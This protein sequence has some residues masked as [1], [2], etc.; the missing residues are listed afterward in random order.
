MS[1]ESYSPVGEALDDAAQKLYVV[2]YATGDVRTVDLTST[3]DHPPTEDRRRLG[4][5]RWRWH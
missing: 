1:T 2:N 5:A 3:S 4:L